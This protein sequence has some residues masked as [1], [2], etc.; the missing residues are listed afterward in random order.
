[1]AVGIVAI[2]DRHVDF[3]VQQICFTVAG[4]QRNR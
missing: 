4:K 3:C 2:V 1:M